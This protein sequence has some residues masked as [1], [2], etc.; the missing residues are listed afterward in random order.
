MLLYHVTACNVFIAYCAIIGSLWARESFFRK[1]KWQSIFLK[2]I[3]LLISKPIIICIIRDKAPHIGRVG[4]T[5]RI[6]YFGD[7]KPAIFSLWVR[8]AGNRPK[9]AI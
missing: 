1:S 2:Y 9:Q 3:F 7:D 5:I 4:C 6:E 8:I